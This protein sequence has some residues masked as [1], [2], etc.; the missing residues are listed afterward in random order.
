MLSFKNTPNEY[1]IIY[2]VLE[3]TEYSMTNNQ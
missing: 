2:T 1:T 3:Y